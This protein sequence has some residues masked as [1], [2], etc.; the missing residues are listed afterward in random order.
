MIIPFK[1]I[2]EIGVIKDKPAHTL[3][4]NAWSDAVNVRF[5]DGYA[6]KSLGYSSQLGTPSIAP[7]FLLPFQSTSLFYWLYA[8]LTS[9]YITEGP[10]HSNITRS[11]GSITVTLT[12]DGQEERLPEYLFF[13]TGLTLRKCYSLHPLAIHCLN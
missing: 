2:G 3:P 7:Y 12:K 1:S 6:E 13:A 10:T 8:G 9:A 11:S 4:L 5:N